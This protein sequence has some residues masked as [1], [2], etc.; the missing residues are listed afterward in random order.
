MQDVI[1][2]QK[3]ENEE[4]PAERPPRLVLSGEFKD[5]LMKQAIA[6]KD[7]FLE[8]SQYQFAEYLGLSMIQMIFDKNIES[9]DFIKIFKDKNGY[10]PSLDEKLV[11]AQKIVQEKVGVFAQVHSEQQTK[12]IEDLVNDYVDNLISKEKTNGGF[13]DTEAMRVALFGQVAFKFE[14][15]CQEIYKKASNKL[16]E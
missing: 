7:D 16:T 4:V 9:P 11:N 1:R 6:L 8:Q 15:R 14:Q 5:S 12:M 10:Q 3:A 13:P 2:G